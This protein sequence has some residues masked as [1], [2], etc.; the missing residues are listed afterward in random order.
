MRLLLCVLLGCCCALL[1][2]LPVLAQ[3]PVSEAQMKEMRTRMR[4][5]QNGKPP[6][7][8]NKPAEEKKEETKKPKDDKKKK[9]DE[10][11]TVKRPTEPPKDVDPNRV[12]LKPGT[13]GRVQFNYFGQ[14]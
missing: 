6:A 7:A 12:K 14:P 1:P 10:I 4:A 11:K 8:Q 13:D 5:Q 2:D 3:H 9:K